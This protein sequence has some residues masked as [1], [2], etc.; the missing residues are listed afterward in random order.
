MDELTDAALALLPKGRAWQG[1]EG[2]P[3]PGSEIG[4]NPE[5]FEPDGFSTTARR[6]S[7]LWQFWRAIAV[8][9]FYLHQRLC[10]LRLELWCAT[11][12]E[13][14]DLWLAEYGLPDGCDPF[15][16]LC[17]KVAAQGGTR[18]EFYQFIAG[19][20]GW[21]IFCR[22]DIGHCGALVGSRRAKA[23]MAK[24]GRLKA[25]QLIIAVD[26]QNSPAFVGTAHARPKAGRL[27]AG[28]RLAC[29]PNLG[30]L[31]CLLGRVV[32]AEIQITY[33]VH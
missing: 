26:L 32:H 24:P 16:D 2:G 30:P 13:T 25:A 19:R 31:E 22:N 21:S 28:R 27:K 18:C 10:A 14:H 8:V 9:L 4:F 1:H 7:V 23:G 11:H 12:S 3:R 33:E 29:G 6:A 20:A 5:A 17:S 15:P